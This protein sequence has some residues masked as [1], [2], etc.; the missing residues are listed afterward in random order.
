[1]APPADQFSGRKSGNRPPAPVTR[2]TRRRC[3]D[4]FS[5]T[6]SNESRGFLS[7]GTQRLIS[8]YGLS[9]VCPLL[10]VLQVA[11]KRSGFTLGALLA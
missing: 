3:Y 11:A 8:I 6:F 4:S 7:K 2:Q 5:S 1:M 9:V 10:L